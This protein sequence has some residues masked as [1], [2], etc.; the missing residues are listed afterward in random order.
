M[1][2]G[3][4]GTRPAVA[5]DAGDR[6]VQI[7]PQ[8]P[9]HFDANSTQARASLAGARGLSTSSLAVINPLT[10][11]RAIQNLKF[12]PVELAT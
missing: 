12:V 6:V 5:P 1:N 7:A 2:D 3:R 8:L 10:A 9:N 11:D 4:P